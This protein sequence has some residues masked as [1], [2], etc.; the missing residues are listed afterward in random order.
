MCTALKGIY[1]D[2]RVKGRKEGHKKGL[3]E[4]IAEGE[5]LIIR[6]LHILTPGSAVY[7]EAL[8]GTSDERK[9]LYKKYGIID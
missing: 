5:S 9:K 4:G 8:N 2:G 1:E 6:L 3:K 7:D